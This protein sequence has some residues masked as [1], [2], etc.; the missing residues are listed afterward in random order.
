MGREIF[1]I[2]GRLVPLLH[3]IDFQDSLSECG[4]HCSC[5]GQC[6]NSPSLNT[7]LKHPISLQNTPNKGISAYANVEIPLASFV[8]TYSGE[9]LRADEAATRLHQYD[10]KKQGHALL[11]LREILP[12]G[13][14]ALRTHIDATKI[15]NVSRFFN[16]RCGG[17]NLDLITSRSPDSLIPRVCL[18]ANRDIQK[19]E[20]LTFAYGP[21]NNNEEQRRACF[22]GSPECLGY[23]PQQ[24]L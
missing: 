19:G 24:D 14:A 3:K 2:T 11:V 20:E 22:C 4:P 18:F 10:L 1:D 8:S 23:L 12:S 9:L 15:G 17:G 6:T 21:P 7:A 16:H 5:S 13:S